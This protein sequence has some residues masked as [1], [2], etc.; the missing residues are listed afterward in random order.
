MLRVGLDVGST[1]VKIVVFDAC[2]RIVFGKYRRHYSDIRATIFD[3]LSEALSKFQDED[4]YFAITG[5]GGMLVA[6]W[7]G[8]PF[9][10]EVAALGKSVEEL[11]PQ[12]DVAI[13]L[14]GEDAKIT[15]FRDP[16]E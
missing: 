7:L 14:G 13:E 2:R 12:T 3:V 6:D 9:V 11:I 5:S 10:Q 16:I 4:C 8:L 1:T 15:F